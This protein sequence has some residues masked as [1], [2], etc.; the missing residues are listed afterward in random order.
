MHPQHYGQEALLSKQVGMDPTA[1]S[2]IFRPT[3]NSAG[4]GR[5]GPISAGSAL[6]PLPGRFAGV[7]C[8]DPRL[9]VA[10]DYNEQKAS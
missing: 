5:T 4:N 3:G 10:G 6:T 9:A 2:E 8:E 7:L 1:P